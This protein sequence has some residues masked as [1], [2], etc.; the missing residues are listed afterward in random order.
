MNL[1]S[2][3]RVVVK[4]EDYDK[5]AKFVDTLSNDEVVVSVEN[6]ITMF[7]KIVIIFE[8]EG[9]KNLDAMYELITH[10]KKKLSRNAVY[11]ES[12]MRERFTPYSGSFDLV[13]SELR[14]DN[15]SVL[16]APSVTVLMYL[17]LIAGEKDDFRKVMND[18]IS[19][20]EKT[21]VPNT[22]PKKKKSNKPSKVKIKKRIEYTINI[23]DEYMKRNYEFVKES[24]T[25]RG[26]WREYKNGKRSW[27][28]AYKKG[29]GEVEAKE[30]T[31]GE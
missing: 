1:K 9:Q 3:D 20:E 17:Y 30:Y 10:G 7:D 5:I 16:L 15:D 25:V 18:S 13:T 14:L 31:I 28:K 27:I 6:I 21:Y 11:L 29:T 23:T 12:D 22:Q 26:H 24:W 2:V 19:M 4:K 8:N